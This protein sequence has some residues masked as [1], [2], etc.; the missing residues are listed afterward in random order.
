MQFA[1]QACLKFLRK[2]VEDF[3][4]EDKR[5]QNLFYQY[6]KITYLTGAID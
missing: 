4:V 3:F 1:P 5:L 6:L 2:L